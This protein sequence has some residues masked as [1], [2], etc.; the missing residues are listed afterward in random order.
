MLEPLKYIV[1]CVALERDEHGKIVGERPTQ[2]Q[3]A[4]SYDEIQRIVSEF[5]QEIERLNEQGTNGAAP[6]Q[7]G[8]Q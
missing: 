5:Q 6:T 1:Q 8:E 7:E 4:Y 3:P 2:A